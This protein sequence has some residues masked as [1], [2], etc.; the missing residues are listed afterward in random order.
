MSVVM[1][2]STTSLA[3]QTSTS[4]LCSMA[5]TSSSNSRADHQVRPTTKRLQI[6]RTP[7]PT[8]ELVVEDLNPN[9]SSICGGS[10]NDSLPLTSLNGKHGSFKSAFSGSAQPCKNGFRVSFRNSSDGQAHTLFAPDE[11][12]KRQ[13]LTALKKSSGQELPAV[14][15][16]D[17][18]S[19]PVCNA[20]TP[21]PAKRFYAQ[22]GKVA[23]NSPRVGLFQV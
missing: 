2:S 13:W 9:A 19:I 1:T 18:S 3:S 6:Y 10:F 12:S 16:T 17:H 8:S 21:T 22:G 11:H 23:K 14:S 5:S 15:E 7:I 20:G 4:S